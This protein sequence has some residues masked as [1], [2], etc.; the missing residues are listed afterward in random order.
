[1]VK[2]GHSKKYVEYFSASSVAEVQISL[3]SLRRLSRPLSRP[4]G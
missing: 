1:M 2:M 4:G 3:R